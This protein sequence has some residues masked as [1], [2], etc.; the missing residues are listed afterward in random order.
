MRPCVTVLAVLALATALPAAAQTIW[1]C[2][3]SYSQTPCESGA[4]VAAAD[5]R[6]AAE[7][8][9]AEAGARADLRRAQALEK[10]R[11][12]QEK[13]APR[14]VVMGSPQAEPARAE[15]ATPADARRGKDKRGVKPPSP[16]TAVAVA[17]PAPRP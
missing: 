8:R 14:A 7:A 5:P 2:G 4:M 1:R 11:L 10:A 3:N 12:A 13:A 15:K 9:Q 17:P 6:T 16:F